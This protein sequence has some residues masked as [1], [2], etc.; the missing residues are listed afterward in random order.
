MDTLQRV[1]AAPSLWEPD[2]SEPDGL[3]HAMGRWRGAGVA[4]WE[5][6]PVAPG[7]S[8]NLPGPAPFRAAAQR[9]GVAI[10][11]FGRRERG[12]VIIDP[13]LSETDAG[14]ARN[15]ETTL[16]LSEHRLE[17][18]PHPVHASVAEASVELLDALSTGASTL[19]SLDVLPWAS[20]NRAAADGAVGRPIPMPPGSDE[21]SSRVAERSFRVLAA[22]EVALKDTGGSRTSQEMTTRDA[23]LREIR[24]VARAAHAA[25]WNA[26]LWSSQRTDGGSVP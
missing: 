9:H 15:L 24:R 19:E 10:L 26:S 7:D 13:L 14:L 3:A 8:A 4:G 16:S 2:A 23:T 21:R 22:L 25:A 12:L 6:V 18:A 17:D 20:S 5:Y 1:H 11:E